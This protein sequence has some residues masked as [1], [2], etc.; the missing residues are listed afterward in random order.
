MV[1]SETN[2]T[3]KNMNKMITQSKND[4]LINF[5]KQT[6]HQSLIYFQLQV[7]VNNLE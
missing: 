5:F 6:C 3:C 7:N 1:N 4:T 2:S